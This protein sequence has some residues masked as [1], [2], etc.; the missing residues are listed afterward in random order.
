M[1][2][3]EPIV[4]FDQPDKV[5]IL[6]VSSVVVPKARADGTLDSPDVF[7][8]TVLFEIAGK[9]P[10]IIARNVGGIAEPEDGPEKNVFAF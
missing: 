2:V 5:N 8:M 10:K 6:L 3:G 7:P 9:S 1:I 4:E